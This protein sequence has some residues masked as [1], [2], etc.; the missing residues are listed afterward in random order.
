MV[1]M[2]ILMFVVPQP[3][4][5]NFNSKNIFHVYLPTI[6]ITY[7][8]TKDNRDCLQILFTFF[9]H[10]CLFSAQQNTQAQAAPSNQNQLQP[11]QANN[12][13]GANGAAA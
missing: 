13:N 4:Q 8:F 7:L 1:T 5:V 9:K 6:I 12:G 10:F 3:L 11:Q 2:V